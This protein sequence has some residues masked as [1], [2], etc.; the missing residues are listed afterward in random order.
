MFFCFRGIPLLVGVLKELQELAH[1]IG[2]IPLTRNVCHTNDVYPK[3]QSNG[4]TKTHVA[5][6]EWCWLGFFPAM[7]KMVSQ[8]R[9]L[10]DAV[11]CLASSTGF[12]HNDLFT[13]LRG[14][15][16]LN[17]QHANTSRSARTGESMGSSVSV[18]KNVN[19]IFQSLKRE[20]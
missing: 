8:I 6:L 18:R 12:Q 19:Y 4:P 3:K 5:Q 15:L 20:F 7:V 17:L 13:S 14:S 9:A 10:N 1:L 2:D 16:I 11:S